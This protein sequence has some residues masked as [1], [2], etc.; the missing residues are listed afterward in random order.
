[1]IKQDAEAN[2][3]AS[4]IV[5]NSAIGGYLD[6][7]T[8]DHFGLDAH[9]LI[10]MNL[11][12]L[13]ERKVAVD[14]ITIKETFNGEDLRAIGGA[15]Y[16]AS[17]VANLPASPNTDS[18]WSIVNDAY[19]RRSYKAAAA[20]VAVKAESGAPI[21]EVHLA[22]DKVRSIKGSDGCP[23]FT[24]AVDSATERVVREK[25]VG[26]DLKFG[27]SGLDSLFGG[28][29]RRLLTTVGG[30]TSHGKTTVAKNIIK[31]LL[32][33]NKTSKILYNGFENIDDFP[34]GLASIDSNVPL[35]W[36]VK[37]HMTNEDQMANVILALDKLHDYKDRL[38]MLNCASI[39]TM[40]QVAR[41][42]GP[43]I[44]VLDYVQRYAAKY[45]TGSE[46]TRHNVAKVTSDL[47]DIALEF[48]CHAFNL[49]QLRRFSEER[50]HKRPDIND[51]KES[52]DIEN[53]SDNIILLYWPWRDTMDDQKDAKNKY[54]FLVAKNKTGPCTEITATIDLNT[55]RIT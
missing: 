31:N 8:P 34:L 11:Q 5:D 16:L 42:F 6:K 4:L 26:I 38:V 47:Q 44:V 45:S 32:N 30:K 50:R 27:I 13:A 18:Y 23:S 33:S 51:L 14:L 54:E 52:G 29:R 1:M 10:W 9:K 48:N 39:S 2:F 40:R 53:Y 43:D 41:E 37:P 36:F 15:S 25:S 20:E 21:E 46:E 12:E 35:D 28:L 22:A 49:S 55:L 7:V 19:I 24:V 3:L 17:L